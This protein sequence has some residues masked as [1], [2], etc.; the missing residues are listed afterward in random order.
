[1]RQAINTSV[2]LF[3]EGFEPRG[4]VVEIGALYQPGYDELCNL[5]RYF[6]GREYIGCDIRYGL[7]VDRIEDAHAL[8]FADRSIGT[9]LLFETLEHL[10]HPG[11]AISEAWRVLDDEGLLAMSVPFNYRLH[12][13]PSDYWR[14]TAS[15]VYALLSDFPDKV[16]FALGPHLK[17]AFIFAIA[18]KYT[19]RELTERKTKFQA[20]VLETFRRSWLRGH[21][22][23]LKERGRDFFG[24][25]LGRAQLSA[26]FF[27]PAQ[28]GGYVPSLNKVER[29]QPGSD[30]S[31]PH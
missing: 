23:V 4:P 8:S 21:I 3:S 15:G 17:P 29:T 18:A 10:P 14:F 9:M 27:D 25:L 6:A 11:K 30:I 20:R 31:Q 5:R 12:G 2:R 19:S 1:M 28:G 22:S 7:G 24:L 26:R 16:V 13:F